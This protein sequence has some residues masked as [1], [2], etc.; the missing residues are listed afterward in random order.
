[1]S[2]HEHWDELAVGHALGALEPEDDQA[3]SEHLRE[4]AQCGRTLADM[5]AVSAQLAYGVEAA[6]PP[7]ALLESIMSEVRTSDRV[8]V[9]PRQP[10]GVTELR[11]RRPGRRLEPPWLAAAAAL[12]LVVVLAGWNVQLRADN[13]AKT[14]ALA[15]RNQV[16]QAL[17]DPGTRSV[18]LKSEGRPQAQVL[19]QGTRAWLVV[20]GFDQN[21]RAQHVYVLWQLSRD[22]K[23]PIRFFDVVHDGP[24]YID[25]GT[26]DG[27]ATVDDFAVSKEPQGRKPVEP[28]TPLVVQPA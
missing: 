9:V 15:V 5:E 19:V 24:N 27:Q 20:N 13:A 6:D 2:G 28:T 18:A 10:S 14:R 21:D 4:C 16:G 22:S 3:F 23:K 7:P 26:L 12:V 17:T 1:M 25:V 11:R 8:A